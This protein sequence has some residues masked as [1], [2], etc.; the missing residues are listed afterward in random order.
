M[1]IMMGNLPI[2]SDDWGVLLCLRS[3]R[4]TF[5]LGLDAYFGANRGSEVFVVPL[6][7]INFTMN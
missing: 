7:Q 2:E 4:C 5:N 1:Q 6:T 3:K